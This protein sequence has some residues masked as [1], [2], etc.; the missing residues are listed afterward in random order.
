MFEPAS[1]G[2]AE[3]MV[4]PAP[5]HILAPPTVLPLRH[6]TM[7]RHLLIHR[8]ATLALLCA[9][10]T[11]ASCKPDATAPRSFTVNPGEAALQIGDSRQFEVVGAPGQVDWSSS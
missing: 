11:S 4:P 10:A 9:L 7:R 8:P 1:M 2:A 3:R 5:S 6:K